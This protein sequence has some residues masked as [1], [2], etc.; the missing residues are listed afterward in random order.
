MKTVATLIALILS[1]AT[2][3]AWPL[4]E[5]NRAIEQTNFVVASG[6]SGTLVSVPQRLLLTNHHCVDRFI[7]VV[8]RDVVGRGG[9]IRKTKVRKYEDVPVAQHGYDGFIRINSS[10]YVS[11]IVAE[12]QQRDLAVL[13]FKGPIPHTYASPLLPEGGSLARGERV[14]VVGN[15]AGNDATVVEGIVSNLN[16]SFE[17]DWADHARLPMIQFSGGIYGGN[18]GGALYND[19]GELIG[20]PAAMMTGVT[21]I[22]L[23]IPVSIVKAFLRDHCLAR[24]FDAAANDDKCSADK[25]SETVKAKDDKARD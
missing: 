17:F 25:R 24:V 16:R 12:Q 21:F 3:Q 23:A 14:Y 11:E 15:P 13:R 19:R 2:S 9:V 18:S 6:C 8:D 1:A 4:E 20:V 22:G 7:S 5:M 10:S